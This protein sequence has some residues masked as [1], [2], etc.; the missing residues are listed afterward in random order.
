MNCVSTDQNNICCMLREIFKD[1]PYSG[2]I[3]FTGNEYMGIYQ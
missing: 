3:L 1:A 2:F